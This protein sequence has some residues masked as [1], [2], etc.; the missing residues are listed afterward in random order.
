[1]NFNGRLVPYILPDVG[2]GIGLAAANVLNAIIAVYRLSDISTP[3]KLVELYKPTTI[4]NSTKL[5]K[6]RYKGDIHYDLLLDGVN[7]DGL[8]TYCVCNTPYDKDRPMIECSN[9]GC[10]FGRWFHYDCVGVDAASIN[11]KEP[12]FCVQCQ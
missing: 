12:Y 11:E 6:L 3:L 4:L 10:K 8:L 9:V 2:N 5:I 1:M 7:D